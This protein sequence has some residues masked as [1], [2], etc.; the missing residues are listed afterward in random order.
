MKN[1]F[2]ALFRWKE[3][4]K[5]EIFWKKKIKD[6]AGECWQP[7]EAKK[8]SIAFSRKSDGVENKKKESVSIFLRIEIRTGRF[9]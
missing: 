8:A 9:L 7:V 4:S 2:V 5:S 1:V 6:F 3:F